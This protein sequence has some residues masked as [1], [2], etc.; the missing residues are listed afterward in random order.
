MNQQHIFL[1]NFLLA[2][3]EPRATIAAADVLE[4]RTGCSP[5]YP[6]GYRCSNGF[7]VHQFSTYI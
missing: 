6:V 4:E 2:Y 5:T 1:T 7:C 3:L